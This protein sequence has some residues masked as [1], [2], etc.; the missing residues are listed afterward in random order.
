MFSLKAEDLERLILLPYKLFQCALE[1]HHLIS[2][3]IATYT[4][5]YIITFPVSEKQQKEDQ[6]LINI[7]LDEIRALENYFYK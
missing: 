2:H 5:I 4:Y 3:I 1:N 7:Q 6:I